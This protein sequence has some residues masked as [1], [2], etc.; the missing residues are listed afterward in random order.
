M[1]SSG[2]KG[3]ASYTA[4]AKD[5]RWAAAFRFSCSFACLPVLQVNELRLRILDRTG[6]GPDVIGTLLVWSGHIQ[7]GWS[8]PKMEQARKRVSAGSLSLSRHTRPHQAESGGRE[9]NN[10]GQ[11]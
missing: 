4:R 9:P 2:I 5:P 7:P 11:T 6:P 3:S 8:P 10:R 1:Q